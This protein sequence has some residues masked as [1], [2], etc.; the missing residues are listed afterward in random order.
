MERRSLEDTPELELSL[1]MTVKFDDR[2]GH[3]EYGFISGWNDR[4]V[5]VR[6]FRHGK[7]KEISEM[8]DRRDLFP[9]KIRITEE[10]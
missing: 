3:Y 10:E 1:G 7:F 2:Y 8:T 4:G 5:F 6:Y 9:V